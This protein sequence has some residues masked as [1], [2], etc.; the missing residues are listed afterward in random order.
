MIKTEKTLTKDITSQK[1]A[2]EQFRFDV[3]RGL[4]SVPK[5]L[6]SKYFYDKT[7]DTLFQQI[8]A[9][10]EYYLTNC[11]MDIFQN[12]TSELAKIILETNGAFDL[13]ELGAGDGTKSAFLLK[14]LLDQKADFNY[15]P[16]DISANILAVLNHKL[17]ADLPELNITC[18]EGEYFK[19]LE[20]ATE[21]SSRRKV[22]L[23]L[24]SNIGNMEKEEALSFCRGLNSYLSSGDIVLMGFDLKKN[25][26][27][28][29]D[30]YNDKAGITAAFNLNLLT[31]INR[32][33]NADFVVEK[34]EHYQ[35]YDPLSGA[36]RSY[37]VSLENQV[38]T[39]DGESIIFD[40]DESVYMELSQKYSLPE[41]EELANN[42]GFETI[43]H[44]M[45]SKAWFADVAWLVA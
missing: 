35:T 45:D 4:R 11:E 6:Q 39:I 20:K 8:M 40:K 37:L 17:K 24:G 43:N 33:L 23:F 14:H 16:I 42:S 3:L 44:I 19:M 10:P 25:P 21:L 18:L 12:K 5:K 22:V 9:M 7:G 41:S 34:F 2:I 26:Q 13:I 29:L 31:R 1:S 30:A 27:I 15:M 36:C 32:E 28:I 38:V